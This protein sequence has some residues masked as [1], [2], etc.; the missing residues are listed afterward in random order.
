MQKT[1]CFLT[2]NYVFV[3]LSGFEFKPERGNITCSDLKQAL[4]FLTSWSKKTPVVVY[5]DLNKLGE[6]IISSLL[7]TDIKV[8]AKAD[9]QPK[10]TNDLYDVKGRF[11]VYN[12]TRKNISEIAYKYDG[13]V[14]HFINSVNV[15]EF[16]PDDPKEVISCVRWF[17]ANCID[18]V[19]VSGASYAWDCFKGEFDNFKELF[20]KLPE[21]IIDMMQAAVVSG[22]CY[23]NPEYKNKG[24][25][26]PV[27]VID[28]NSMYAS[29]LA[30]SYMP[31]GLPEVD[32]KDLPNGLEEVLEDTR[33]FYF[34]DADIRL[35]GLKKGCFP[36]LT[37][38]RTH[39]F[40][41]TVY[42]SNTAVDVTNSRLVG[43]YKE[44]YDP[45][46]WIAKNNI[47]PVRFVLTEAEYSLMKECYYFQVERVNRVLGFKKSDTLFRSFM[48]K[49]YRLRKGN[50]VD[51]Y[52]SKKVLVSV[53]GKFMHGNEFETLIYSKPDKDSLQSEVI[54]SSSSASY[55]PLYVACLSLARCSTIHDALE[56]G[57]HF[58]YADTDSVH[59]TGK[60]LQDI[61]TGL[62]QY[63]LERMAERSIYIKKKAYINEC[64]GS[65]IIKMSGMQAATNAFL[66]SKL[67][68]G[69]LDLS[70]VK[71][72]FSIDAPDN[73]GE[74]LRIT[75]RKELEQ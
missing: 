38:T 60:T 3:N 18:K 59:H 2:N 53:L 7:S 71:S 66:K 54:N 4:N 8:L 68:A 12:A 55:L 30:Y 1:I 46:D 42:L 20:P 70:E 23:V 61:G 51:N 50:E 28:K 25:D 33:Y 34:I 49:F 69:E 41:P 14:V 74:M 37:D 15:C 47:L 72:N 39:H 24:I 16:A 43:A 26:E 29:E 13:L 35:L 19:K 48:E 31:Y 27:E 5:C 56:Y 40:L 44:K 62:G 64:Q 6:D 36:F 58:V 75:I 73:N 67:D 10:F 65:H 17:M 32:I 9:G 21:G 22:W 11:M 57:K 52:C 63:K 45:L